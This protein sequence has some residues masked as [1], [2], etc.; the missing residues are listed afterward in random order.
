MAYS[1]LIDVASRLVAD[2]RETG[3][4]IAFKHTVFAL[5]FAVIS[6]IT[7]ASPGWPEPRVWLWVAVAMVAA[8][9]A[10]MAFNRLADHALDAENPRTADR[11]LPAGRLSR[12]FTSV[13]TAVS[14]AVF[15]LAAA[16]LN[17]LCLVLAPPTLAVLLGYSYAKRFTA[18]AHLW[19]G[20]ALGIAPV[21]AWIAVAGRLSWPPLV[22]AAA[23]SL[24]VAGF[25]VI[26]SLQDESFDRGRALHSLPAR[27]GGGRALQLARLFHLLAFIGF[28]IFA[29]AAG[30]G[31]FR[32]VAV[33]G[34]GVL[35][36]W[37]HRLIR[38]DD[39]HRV[40]AVFFTTNGA[41]A[42]LMCILFL[43]AKYIDA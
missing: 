12:R 6:L 10:A 35:L 30:G 24:W 40:D 39:L 5:P 11:A 16:E 13:V 2:L 34:A 31:V 42:L 17:R 20:I 14:A 21:G 9:T 18:G 3:E 19:L 26:Y 7:A 29:A 27:L 36:A 15:V 32:L 28:A 33:G 4:M 22:L 38:A 1:L 25:D 8:R 23:V 43:F 41:L 37:Q